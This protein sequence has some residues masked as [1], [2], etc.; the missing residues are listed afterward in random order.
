VPR[1]GYTGIKTKDTRGQKIHDI[2][3]ANEQRQ[4]AINIIGLFL[5]SR[6]R[7]LHHEEVVDMLNLDLMDTQAGQD[8]YRMGLVRGEVEGKAE[9]ERSVFTR[10]LK[11]RFG[12]LS[13]SVQAR[14]ENAT[15]SQL[16][17]WSL[18][19]LDAKNLDDVFQD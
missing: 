14:I 9:G 7:K 12:Q 1:F 4:E 17:Q 6:F 3:P 13:N 10:Q 2:Y 8:I 16:E 15:L 5:L 11:K 19:I 18:N